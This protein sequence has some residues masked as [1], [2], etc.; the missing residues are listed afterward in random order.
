MENCIEAAYK[1][2]CSE[3]D[4]ALESK[5]EEEYIREN[6]GMLQEVLHSECRARHEGEM[7]ALWKV[8]G[9]LEVELSQS[10]CKTAKTESELEQRTKEM[11]DL[12]STVEDA[13]KMIA[14]NNKKDC[15][16]LE[17]EKWEKEKL[18]LLHDLD[19]K[20]KAVE[21][22]EASLK[23]QVQHL[24]KTK[25]ENTMLREESEKY[26]RMAENVKQDLNERLREKQAKLTE[27]MLE[28]EDQ[29]IELA[30]S[31]KSNE[32][33]GKR[34]EVMEMKLNAFMTALPTPDRSAPGGHV[35]TMQQVNAQKTKRSRWDVAPPGD[36]NSNKKLRQ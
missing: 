20:E 6:V 13:K 27:L 18:G 19:G 12:K 32:Q 5:T 34:M 30:R 29:S 3:V 4:R 26:R 8:V 14:D 28:L 7:L 17:K 1:Q 2:A 25:G 33:L 16:A 15:V 35:D 36:K 21:E 24:N 22:M 31:K 10:L 11:Q 9:G 23:E